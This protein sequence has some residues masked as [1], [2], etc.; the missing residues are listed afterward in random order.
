MIGL[1]LDEK[2]TSRRVPHFVVS[3]VILLTILFGTNL[4]NI[5]RIEL[6]SSSSSEA[7]CP[8]FEPIAPVSYLKDNSTV[9]T[10]LHD[11]DYKQGSIKKLS[12]A[13]QVDTQI[14]DNQPN[15]P[16]APEVWA[17]FK[18]FHKYLEETFPIIYSNLEVTKVNTYGLV[19]LWKGSN[20]DLKPLLLTAHQDVVP[21]QKDTLDDWTYPPFEGH[22]DGKFIYGRGASDCKNVLIAILETVELLLNQNYHPQRS[23]L[24]AFGFDEEA[25]GVV[26]ASAIGK[27]LEET[28]GKD[29]LYA[30]IDEGPGL[31]IDDLTG[32]IVATPGTGEKGYVDI[33]VQ[34]TTPGGHSSIP[35]DHTSIGILSELAYIIEKDPYSPILTT[36]NPTLS[37][38]Q[39]LASHDSK[40]KIPSFTKKSILRAGYDKFANSKVIQLVQK[41]RF[42]K[43]LVQTSQ[44]IDI[45]GGGEKANALPEHVRLL[46]NHRVAIESN[47]DSVKQHFVERVI[48]VAKRHNLSVKAYGELVL[49]TKDNSGV[50]EVNVFSSPL[51]TAPT[52]PLND[53]VWKHLAGVTRHV[54]EDLVYPDLDYPI[55]TSPSIMTGNTDTRHYWNLTRNIFRYSPFFDVSFLGSSNVHSVDEKLPFAGH[56][57]LTAFFYEYI[58]AVDTES[59]NN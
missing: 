14:F 11:E 4:F 40:N 12:G 24:L 57:Q 5:L 45:I 54:F 50:F 49:D 31:A 32:T 30:I 53:N 13:I 29:S 43:Y 9:L 55:I 38:Y 23:L 33:E 22:Y 56:L 46:V 36:K 6:S 20:E 34:L 48:Q 1:P 19:Y 25:S 28:Y 16:D 2:I 47:V 58:Q 15:V 41:N 52:T 26:G 18:N 59:A 51:E 42:T 8:L 37:Y 35:P 39:C 44:A 3:I 17:K 27:Y 7:L 21:V 10:I